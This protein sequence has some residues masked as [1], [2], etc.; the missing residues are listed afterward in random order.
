M[1]AAIWSDF[2]TDSTGGA[3]EQPKGMQQAR[4]SVK[5]SG[6]AGAYTRFFRGAGFLGKGL[7]FALD[8]GSL[9]MLTL[10]PFALTGVVAVLGAM[11]FWGWAH[12][13]AV[14]HAGAFFGTLLLILVVMSVGFFLFVAV[15]FIATAP[16]AGM[17][18]SRT[19]KLKAGEVPKGD[20][21]LVEALRGT[22]HTLVA[23][24]VYLGVQALVVAL[25]WILTP[26]SPFFWLLGFFFTA[27]F[28]AYDAFDLPLS[29]RKTSLGSKWSFVTK[30][31]AES[32]GFGAACA[33]LLMIPGFNLLVPALAY[34]GGTLLYLE[35]S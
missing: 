31:F 30:H 23:L 17:I 28:I 13:W 9:L 14:A 29:R 12:A 8:H 27:W 18:S 26:L 34:V 15:S 19:E 16:F 10:L 1:G 22:F 35:L 4:K 32:I 3:V 24:A 2:G 7:G 6:M 5:R 21:F 20:N 25:G 33:L 11:A